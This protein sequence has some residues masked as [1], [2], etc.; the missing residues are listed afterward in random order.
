[1]TSDTNRPRASSTG[2]KPDWKPIDE[3]PTCGGLELYPVYDGELMNF[4]C[5]LCMSCWHIEL[6]FIHKMNPETCPGCQY[7]RSC[8]ERHRAFARPGGTA[9]A[10][11]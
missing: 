1:M 2:W 5:P 3:C 10:E 7:Q 9:D 4:L 6:G 8:Q 11:R